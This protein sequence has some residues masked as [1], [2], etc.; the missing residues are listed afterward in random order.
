[1]ACEAALAQLPATRILEIPKRDYSDASSSSLLPDSRSNSPRLE[2]SGLRVTS[3]VGAFT[4]ACRR[5]EA[6][7]GRELERRVDR[8]GGPASCPVNLAGIKCKQGSIEGTKRNRSHNQDFTNL[9]RLLKL[10]K[11]RERTD[12]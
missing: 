2:V 4:P 5:S 9:S 1:M 10:G 12:A 11:S 3:E 7:G 8:T 6:C